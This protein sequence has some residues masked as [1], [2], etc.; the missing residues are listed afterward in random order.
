VRSL[1]TSAVLRAA[2][3]AVPLILLSLSA[4]AQAPSSPALDPPSRK[5]S[6]RD[7][8]DLQE[9]V[10]EL[11]TMVE[12]MREENVQSRAEMQQLRQELQNTRGLLERSASLA[13]IHPT[14]SAD[15]GASSPAAPS[16]APPAA[17]SAAQDES[18]LQD[19]VQKLEESTSLLGSKID[20]QYQTKVETASKYRARLSG[21][22]L[23]NAFRNVGTSDN[24]DFPNIAQPLSPNYTQSSFGATL[25]Q[26]EIGLEVFGPTLAGAKT[27]ANVQLD[28]AG[29]FAAANNGVNFGIARL[30]TASLHLDWA[31]SSVIAGQDSLFLSP[32]SPTSFASLA[33]PTFAYAGN[34]W[35]WIPQIRVEHR[36]DLSDAQ[37]ITVQAGILD[38]LD[39]Q[40]PPNP[41]FRRAQAG[42]QSGQPAYGVRTAWSHML[43]G[44]PLSFGTAGYY[45][46]QNWAWNRYTDA[47][48][49]MTDWQFPI[50]S[51]LTLSGEFYRGRGVGGLGAGIGRAVLFGGD[52]GSRSTPLRGLDAAGGW[53]QLKFQLTP[54]VEFNGT[55]AEDN[56]FAGD[57]R[58]FAI[59]T[60]NFS[61]ILGRNH[62][63]L[64]NVVYRPRSD[65]LFSAEFRRLHS[66]PVY[67]SSSVTN[68]VNLAI[69]V[70]F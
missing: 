68:Q 34:L 30:Q 57:V 24:L 19:R 5:I 37:A 6:A 40:P 56:A 17:G 15:S 54:K 10:R 31:H 36:F 59:D 55:F 48:A 58:G 27:S 12:E 13:A 23:M 46:R 1:R 32:L 42:E 63:A 28:F 16:D 62:G 9:Q 67:T 50:A 4:R 33:V 66:F 47:W 41:Y 52:P 35:G 8:R 20:E 69:G 60:N 22:I 45:G 43:F 61:T 64:G 65:L 25:R 2:S 3:V 18:S 29:G 51:R 39:W 26:S 14:S 38:N 7:V 11:R 21:I 53:S 49:G 44:R 70:L